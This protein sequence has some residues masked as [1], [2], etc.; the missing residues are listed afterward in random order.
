MSE[1]LDL[2]DIKERKLL[3]IYLGVLSFF[4]GVSIATAIWTNDW[5]VW[6]FGNDILSGILFASL[7]AGFVFTRRFW[8]KG[9]VPSRRIIIM[10]LKFSVVVGLIVT[11]I[12]TILLAYYPEEAFDDDPLEPISNFEWFVMVNIFFIGGFLA[13]LLAFLFYLV[14]A[15]GFVGVVVMF[16]V[17]LTPVL[18]RRIRGITTTDEREARF[19]AWFMLIPE[20]LDTGTLTVDRPVKEE[21]FPWSRF[22]HAISWQIMISL[23]IAVTLSLNPFIKDTIDPSQILSLLTNANI[24]VPLIIIPTLLYLRLNVRIEGPVKEFMIYKGFQ[25]RLIRTFF[26]AGTI[27]LILRLAVKE[28]TSQ[29]FL[30]SFSGYAALSVSIIVFFT[31]IYYNFFEN[32]AA[33]RVAER[34]PELMKG[35]VD[36]VEEGE[37]D[38]VEEG[39]VED[40][41]LPSPSPSKED[42]PL[43]VEDEE[44]KGEL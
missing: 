21:A 13:G 39:E 6:T 14:V 22:Y 26:A 4:W 5:S 27:I 30:L 17:G 42:T 15:M 28:V 31:W 23:L 37:V 19:L 12:F 32:F 35:E 29:D 11:I 44:D 8:G 3:Y 9:I 34:I 36:E 38:E 18:I 25:S 16:E 7:F 10:M 40:A 1:F 33:F 43:D 41:G 20:N 2:W 24:V